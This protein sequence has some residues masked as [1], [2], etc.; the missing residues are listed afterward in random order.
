M[1]FDQP[2]E[3][4]VAKVEEKKTLDTGAVI[5]KLGLVA[6]DGEK[7]WP[8]EMFCPKGTTPPSEGN[9]ETLIL[10]AP[11]QEGWAPG[12]SRPRKGGGGGRGGRSPQNDAS[13]EA[14]VALKC[15]IQWALANELN[16]AEVIPGLTRTFAE[17]IRGAKP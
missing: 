1:N 13:I 3:F 14:Q 7:V 17:A 8:T 16:D 11:K 9:N 4:T 12:V 15:A 6:P 10:T 2:T 5:Y